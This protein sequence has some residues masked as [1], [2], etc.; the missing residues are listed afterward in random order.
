[1][2]TEALLA[3]AL[4][5]SAAQM[6]AEAPEPWESLGEWRITTYCEACND[7]GGTQTASGKPA[8]TGHVAMNGVPMGSTISIEGD[9]FTVTDRCGVD[10]TV[11]IF[12]PT[13]DGTCHCDLLEY[14][15]VKLKQEG[16]E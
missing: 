7:P 13:P 1:M 8:E 16:K 15:E 14:E 11:D 10:G 5:L 12:V 3:G 4:A 9:E 6:P 2:I